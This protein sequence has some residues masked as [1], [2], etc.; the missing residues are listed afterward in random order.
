MQMLISPNPK[1]SQFSHHLARVQL[2]KIPLWTIVA[3]A[4]IT[5]VAHIPDVTSIFGVH[6]DYV[7][8]YF[9]HNYGLLFH[10]APSL[11]AVAR[12]IFALLG[13][14]TILPIESFADM[15]WHR[16]FTILL[17]CGIGIFMIRICIHHLRINAT[18]AVIVT[19]ATFFVPAFNYSI[20]N[21]SAWVPH[22]LTLLFSFAA[23]SVLARTNIQ[24]IPFY[25][26]LRR[27]DYRAIWRQLVAYSAL[28]S[29]L[30]ASLI[31]Q[32]GFY[33]Y[34]ANALILI[35]FPVIGLL[36]SRSSQTYRTLIGFRDIIFVIANL[37]I[38]FLTARFIYLPIT[39]RILHSLGFTDSMM[40]IAPPPGA[41]T[42][43]KSLASGYR[44]ALDLHIGQV[45]DRA[46]NLLHVTGNMWFLPQTHAW[47]LVGA[48]LVSAFLLAN[49]KKSSFDLMHSFRPVDDSE[50]LARLKFSTWYSNGAI[51]TLVIIACFL[52]GSAPVLF[53]PRNFLS[54]RVVVAS[55]AI[56]AIAF[57]FSLRAIVEMLSRRITPSNS[58]VR[59][60]GNTATIIVILSGLASTYYINFA[61]ARLAANELAFVTNI[62]RT[63]LANNS[64][65]VFFLDPRPPQLPEETPIV[66][67]QRGRAVPPYSLACLSTYC[68]QPLAI[69]KLVLRSLGHSEN[70][71]NFI[72][73]RGR[74]LPG[75]TC[76]MFTS[77]PPRFPPGTDPRTKT[78]VLWYRSQGPFTCVENDLS[79]HNIGIDLT[80]A[81]AK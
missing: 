40:G 49:I 50:D 17:T 41:T 45:L 79:W 20:L 8:L 9:K 6:N 18:D 73:I 13:N 21:I 33:N 43:E 80:R 23:Y 27:R 74:S 72:A 10:E 4:A 29:I 38:Y 69:F 15:R 67:D 59:R 52:I 24:V 37:G 63:A 31:Y 48:L 26:L 44:F 81:S 62:V 22:L 53:A 54:Y 76:D 70:D 47:V 60:F 75:V 39:L 11:F 78:T 36:F 19:A 77:N 35:V 3:F 71:L 28:P 1:A 66:Y 7:V 16:V 2:F 5:I 65:N 68:L 58:T 30:Y 51:V 12:P 42:F 25:P 55:T 57:V 56:V 14:L 34:P 46:W 32:L 61:T 64:V